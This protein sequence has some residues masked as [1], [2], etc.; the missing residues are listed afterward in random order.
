MHQKTSWRFWL[1]QCR[2][3]DLRAD[4]EVAI[5]SK[6]SIIFGVSSVDFSLSGKKCF[7]LF[8]F[9]K[10]R[11]PVTGVNH[12]IKESM[13][14]KGANFFQ[15]LRAATVRRLQWLHHKRLGCSKR[16][17]GLYSVWTREPRQ[18][19]ARFAWRDGLLYGFLGPHPSGRRRR[20]FYRTRSFE[21]LWLNNVIS[22]VCCVFFPP[23]LG[24]GMKLH[25]G[26]Y[27]CRTRR[28]HTVVAR[29]Q[30]QW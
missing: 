30:S 17:A 1:L 4:R 25:V 14:Q 27:G 18:H 7:L 16:N 24:L 6:E 2:L 22:A 9:F 26:F 20:R 3:Y 21:L 15:S 12:L 28:V 19:I 11:Q 29:V 13:S 8:S 23:D 5:Y 10:K